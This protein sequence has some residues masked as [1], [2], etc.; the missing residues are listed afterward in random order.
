[1]AV[2]D[3]ADQLFEMGFSEQLN[4]ILARLPN[5]RQTM[6]FSATLPPQ[7]LEFAKA[8]LRDPELVRLDIER[9]L[10]EGAGLFLKLFQRL[11]FKNQL[12]C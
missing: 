4:E 3:E 10:P 7:I 5:E 9:R 11:I 1:M 12:K 6:L 8:G 2:F